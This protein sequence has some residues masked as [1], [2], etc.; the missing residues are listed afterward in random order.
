MS[1]VPAD[2]KDV[3]EVKQAEAPAEQLSPAGKRSIQGLEPV[4]APEPPDPSPG[5]AEFVVADPALQAELEQWQHDHDPAN[6]EYKFGSPHADYQAAK[7]LDAAQRQ[8][9]VGQQAATAD[10]LGEAVG[11]T[12]AAKQEAE[13]E[14]ETPQDQYF[15]EKFGTAPY[16]TDAYPKEDEG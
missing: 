16:T 9:E 2:T 1:D 5:Q 3:T 15:R 12:L 8:Y 13:P 10:S 14:K 7:D 4:S 6:W 11:A